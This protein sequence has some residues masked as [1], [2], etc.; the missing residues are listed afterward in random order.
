MTFNNNIYRLAIEILNYALVMKFLITLLQTIF[1]K[2]IIILLKNVIQIVKNV[3][4]YPH[5]A[6]NVMNRRISN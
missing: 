4:V 2:V 5:I 1:V 3:L 6:F